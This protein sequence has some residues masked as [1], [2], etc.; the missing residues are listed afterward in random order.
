MSTE[1]VK[2]ILDFILNTASDAEFNVIIKACER[3]RKNSVMFAKSGGVNPEKLA[4]SMSKEISASMGASMDSLRTMVKGY[5]KEIIVKNAPD[6]TNEQ[7]EMVLQEYMPPEGKEKNEKDSNVPPDVMASMIAQFVK[8]SKGAMAPS[9][10]KE[11]WD[12]EPRWYENYW[13]LFSGKIRVL[14]DAYTKNR[15]DDNTFWS[16]IYSLLGL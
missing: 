2:D 8:Y 3:R 4:S 6:I 9:E 11:L 1:K 13:R 14:I 12:A 15:V 10:Q 16:A 5:V 7:L